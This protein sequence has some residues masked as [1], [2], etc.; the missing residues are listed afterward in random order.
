MDS[1]TDNNDTFISSLTALKQLLQ[2]QQQQKSVVK[3]PI[4]KSINVVDKVNDDLRKKLIDAERVIENERS[5]RKTLEKA[6]DE[7]TVNRKLLQE[8]LDE[9]QQQIKEQRTVGSSSNDTDE[10]DDVVVMDS[11]QS[12]KETVA[13]DT[14]SWEMERIQLLQKI[15][16]LE[17]D[18]LVATKEHEKYVQEQ[19]KIQQSTTAAA[20][21]LE[22][23]DQKRTVELQTELESLRKDHETWLAIVR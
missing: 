11:D 3:S 22:A 7:L 15:Q 18:A 2:Q 20:S 5:L 23:V 12:T 9:I 6:F 8:Q 19:M 21:E 1:I 14:S 13:I 10:G 4:T 16:Q 17:E